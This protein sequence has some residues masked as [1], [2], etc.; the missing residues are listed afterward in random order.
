[1]AKHMWAPT[2]AV[3]CVSQVLAWTQEGNDVR[4]GDWSAREI[5]IL[6]SWQLLTAKPVVYLVN[7]SAKVRG[8][9]LPSCTMIA[10]MHHDCTMIAGSS[11]SCKCLMSGTLS[12]V[13]CC[14]QC[15]CTFYLQGACWVMHLQQGLKD[16][17]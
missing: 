12:P 10:M 4:L 16:M 7:M 9:L 11:P 15:S 5:E 8:V 6:N 17:L 14:V 3:W 1:M 13:L 2:I